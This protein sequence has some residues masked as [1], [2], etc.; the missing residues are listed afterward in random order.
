MNPKSYLVTG[1][2]GFIGNAVVR[3]LLRDG[4]RVRVLDDNSRGHADRLKDLTGHF[5]F[6]KGDIRDGETVQRACSGVESVCHLAYINGTEFFYTKPELILEVAVA[7]MMNVLNGCRREG[8]RELVLASSSEVYQTPPVVPTGEQV[9]LSVPDPLNP[10]YSYGGGKIISEL[11]AINYGR[12]FFDRVVI[13][14]PH[15]VYGPDMGWEHVVPQF[16]LRMRELSRTP[17]SIVR[18][19]IQGSGKETRAFVHIDDF[20]DGLA[21]VLDRG[22]HLGIYNIGTVE[23]TSIEAVAH[24]VGHCFGRKVEI[25]PGS[26]QPGS[27]LRRCPDIAKLKH[28]GYVPRVSFREGLPSVARWYDENAHLRPALTQ[29]VHT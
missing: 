1:G 6:I 25:V 2:T 23:E 22:E 24:A 14:R 5:E 11:L 15:N 10:R 27:T 19:P 3:R 17:G 9:P 20:A 21:L 18:F 26:L 28:I 12:A 16:V 7:G 8:V 13:F 4:H 29:P